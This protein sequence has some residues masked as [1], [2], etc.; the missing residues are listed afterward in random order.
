[1]EGGD[2][3]KEEEGRGGREK[4]E[5]MG[6]QNKENGGNEKGILQHISRM[7]SR[8]VVSDVY[9]GDVEHRSLTQSQLITSTGGLK[10]RAVDPLARS[11]E[12]R[13]QWLT[14]NS[15]GR[16]LQRGIYLF[17]F[18]GSAPWKRAMKCAEKRT[19][20]VGQRRRPEHFM[21]HRRQ[22]RMVRGSPLTSLRWFD[23][24]RR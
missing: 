23:M 2:E 10:V 24:Q 13:H 15:E 20:V 18:V 22:G 16:Q 17:L 5:E 14:V 19:R 12:G 6:G 3:R 1:M 7:K 11:A 9:Q 21:T 4:E 8:G